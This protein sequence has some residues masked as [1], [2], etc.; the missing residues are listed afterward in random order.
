MRYIRG[1]ISACLISMALSSP[2][3]AQLAPAAGLT[4]SSPLYPFRTTIELQDEFFTGAN[5]NGLIGSLGWAVSGGTSSVSS[6]S[7]AIGFLRRD[8]SAV[9]ATVAATFNNTAGGL[10]DP[11]LDHALLWRV[12]IVTNDNATTV[13]VG[14]NSQTSASPP[15][16]GIYFERLDTDTNWFCVTRAANVQTRTDSGVATTANFANLAY[17]RD[18]NGVTWSIDQVPVCGTSTTNIPTVFGSAATQ[19]INTG[20]VA[21]QLDHDYFQIRVTKLN[22]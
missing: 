10:L 6:T 5:S 14:E 15:P 17:T 9:A 2:L 1:F 16:N 4:E 3:S 20:A 22:R 18:S 11:G 21:K 8:T 7:N 12:R 19:V 13:R